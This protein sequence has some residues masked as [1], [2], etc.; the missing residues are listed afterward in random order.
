[1]YPPPSNSDYKGIIGTILGSSCFLYYTT[2]TGWGVLLRY[3][4]LSLRVYSLG[5][6][7]EPSSK[8]TLSPS[9]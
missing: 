4:A 1:M 6:G 5:R 7:Q 2:I 9:A 3:R 8:E